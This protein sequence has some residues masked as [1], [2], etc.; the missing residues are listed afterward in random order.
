MGTVPGRGPT[1]DLCAKTAVQNVKTSPSP[2]CDNMWFC[3]FIIA[4]AAKITRINT[5]DGLWFENDVAVKIRTLCDIMF[6]AENRRET[7]KGCENT[8]R[9]RLSATSAVAVVNRL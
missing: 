7:E 1:V 6:H 2:Y 9:S 8:V 5:C 4:G 3:G